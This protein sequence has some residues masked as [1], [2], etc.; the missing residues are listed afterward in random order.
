MEEWGGGAPP[1]S[2]PQN[3]LSTHS[4]TATLAADR[5]P[6][7]WLTAPRTKV[8]APVEGM[9]LA[10]F[11]F[12]VEE[13]LCHSWLGVEKWRPERLAECHFCASAMGLR[14][15][16]MVLRA[17]GDSG[18]TGWHHQGR[19]SGSQHVPTAKSKGP[20][21]TLVLAPS[22]SARLLAE[23]RLAPGE[24]PTS[25]NVFT[26]TSKALNSMQATKDAG[27]CQLPA[28]PGLRP[29]APR[30]AGPAGVLRN[31]SEVG[32]PLLELRLRS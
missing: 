24:H 28:A 8:L 21:P 26:R 14:K 20:W 12:A 31:S 1:C 4:K 13:I 5:M 9:T 32:R 15:S 16:I 22:A 27:A 6:V 29:G 30:A 17:S 7:L 11:R 25:E 18:V 19:Q 2:Q 10:A 3:G 23:L